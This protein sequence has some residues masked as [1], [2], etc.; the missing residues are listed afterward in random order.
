[1]ARPGG[2]VGIMRYLPL[3]AALFLAALVAAAVVIAVAALA[4]PAAAAPLSLAELSGYLNG[5][6][7]VEAAFTQVNPDGTI[8]T[9]R[10]QI[11]RP[12]RI[13]FAYDPPERTL[14]LSDGQQVAVFDGKSNQPPAQYPLR[15]TPLHL[16][17]A[18]Q[19]DLARARMVVG[20]RAEAGMT[21][22]IMQD[23]DNPDLGTI[24]LVF[25]ADPIA[26]RQWVVTDAIGEQTMLILDE[27]AK[28]AALDPNLFSIERELLARGMIPDR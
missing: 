7:T 3:V 27:L 17:L 21:R 19:V 25:S 8:A 22:V 13:R 6:G 18:P 1:M 4:R 2:N 9:G 24:E 14:V 15:R 5:L 12:G 10:V 11:A 26:L 20:H 23:P 16:I 28:G